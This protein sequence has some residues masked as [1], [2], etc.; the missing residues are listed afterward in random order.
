MLDDH[1]KST[2]D[3]KNNYNTIFVLSQNIDKNNYESSS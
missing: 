1:L 3:N 2:T